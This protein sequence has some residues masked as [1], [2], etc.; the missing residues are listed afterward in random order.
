[1]VRM[2]VTKDHEGYRV[3][4]VVLMHPVEAVVARLQG[5]ARTTWRPAKGEVEVR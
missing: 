2:R 1:M 4:D 3:G 5:W